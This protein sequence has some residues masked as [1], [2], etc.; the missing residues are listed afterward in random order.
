LFKQIRSLY[1]PILAQITLPYII[2]AILVAAGGTYIVTRV[3]F[4]S[5]QER[6]TNQL[7]ETGLLA[8]EAIVREE[9]E[10]LEALRLVSH[11]QGVDG[12]VEG[13][14]RQTLQQ[15]ILPVAYNSNLEAVVLLDQVGKKVLAL[16]LN[17]TNQNYEPMQTTISFSKAAFVANVLQGQVDELGDKFGGFFLTEIGET[18]FVAG[19]IQTVDGRFVG[20]AL[21]GRSA[22]GLAQLLRQ[23]TLAQVTFYSLDGQ[24][25]SS[26]LSEGQTIEAERVQEALARQ[27]E[28]SLLRSFQDSGIEYNE[29]LAPLEVRA[30]EDIGLMG[31]AL[32][33]NFLVQTS[34]VT[35]TNTLLLMA[36]ALILVVVV[37]MLV[38]GRITRPIQDLKEAAIKVAGGNLQIQVPRARHDEVGVLTQSFNSMV[39]SLSKS[40]KDLLDTYD[41]TIEGWSRAVDLRDHVTEGHSR[42]VADLSVA[43]ASAMGMKGVQLE[44]LR[45][46]A[47]LH[48]VGK[49]AIPDHI[50]LKKGK[51]TA[52]ETKQMQQHPIYAKEFMEQIDFLKPAMDI[53]HFHHEKWDGS[54]YPT[55]LKGKKIP[56]PA[57]IFAVV[58]VWDAL[59]SDR[60]YRKAMGVNETMEYIDSE[61]NHHF[62]PEVVEAFKKLIGK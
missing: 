17:E 36:V 42:R 59:T 38:A 37:G 22:S 28:G 7:I 10:L 35:R 3:I 39:S 8:D 26:T 12:A 52:K 61:S 29:L 11:I 44:H 47:L 31:V 18:F 19:P 21:V 45:R 2:L 25:L 24:P 20:V 1:I 9:Q 40:K 32:P 14:D 16:A 62:D 34:Q 57:R 56:L 46:G 48:D 43:L 55:G 54:G 13:N 30:G 6:F 50:L 60:P 58:D 41:R 15:L 23:E 27:E 4:D 5:V 49:I 33:T 53:P 51:L